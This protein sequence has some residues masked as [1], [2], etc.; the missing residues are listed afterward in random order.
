MAAL[1]LYLTSLVMYGCL[2]PVSRPHGHGFV[3]DDAVL[4]QH[5]DH[6]A[7]MGMG[8]S[9]SSGGLVC[10][11]PITPTRAWVRQGRETPH[12]VDLRLEIA[13]I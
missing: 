7:H 6:H 2:L 13:E 1:F 3:V 9:D 10:K 5:D 11:P 8:S 12:G 4:L